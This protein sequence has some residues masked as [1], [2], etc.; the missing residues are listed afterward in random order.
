MIIS[1]VITLH[2]TW[3]INCTFPRKNNFHVANGP[4]F[5]LAK[6][7]AFHTAKNPVFH[8]GIDPALC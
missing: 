4:A 3:R 1:I 2:C 6:S 5:L 8:W 7:P